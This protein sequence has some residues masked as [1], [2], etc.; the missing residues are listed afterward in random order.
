MFLNECLYLY[1]L[2]LR[3]LIRGGLPLWRRL[4]ALLPWRRILSGM[5]FTMVAA[6]AGQSFNCISLLI[7][8]IVKIFFVDLVGHLH[9]FACDVFFWFLIA[10]KIHFSVGG[11]HVTKI[12]LHTQPARECV[13]YAIQ[14]L[15]AYI[16]GE[17]LQILILSFGRSGEGNTNS[18]HGN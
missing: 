11:G 10:G 8:S 5:R 13:H 15:L 3:R 12:A 9:H 2:I 1:A 18:D 6:I 16:F 14:F 7:L 4:V 17:N